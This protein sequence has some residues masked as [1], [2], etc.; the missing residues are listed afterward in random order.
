M[1]AF[2]TVQLLYSGNMLILRNSIF[3]SS[4]S[5]ITDTKLVF[6][7]TKSVPTVQEISDDLFTAV[8]TGRVDLLNITPY[9]I[10]VNGSSKFA[11]ISEH[12]LQF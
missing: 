3:S 12:D 9:S 7:S 8:V 6:N 4:G 11:C 1:C 5:V 10:S 2:S